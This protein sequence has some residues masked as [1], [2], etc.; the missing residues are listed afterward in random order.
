MPILPVKGLN[1]RVLVTPNTVVDPVE[2][3]NGINWFILV[4]FVDIKTPS[5]AI[6]I[7][8]NWDPS[9]LKEVAVTIPDTSTSPTTDNLE[10][11]FVD[12]I[13][14]LPET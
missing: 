3:E 11:G 5:E 7:P 4:V 10:V 2:T 1:V 13:P 6:S 9:P 8:V 14:I 12:P